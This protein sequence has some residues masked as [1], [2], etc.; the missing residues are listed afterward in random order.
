MQD[1]ELQGA[2]DEFTAAMQRRLEEKER[3]G[4]AGWDGPGFDDY[5][6][7]FRMGRKSEK[8]YC[9]GEHANPKDLVDIANFAML[10]YHKLT[11]EEQNETT[12]D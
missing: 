4:Y 2:L 3:E 11:R 5:D 10:L 12:V 7:P 6:I 9:N 8:V 1:K